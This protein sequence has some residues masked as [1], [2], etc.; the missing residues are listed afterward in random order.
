MYIMINQYFLMMD[1][2]SPSITPYVSAPAAVFFPSSK[3]PLFS[4]TGSS[5]VSSEGVFPNITVSGSWTP[6]NLAAL[7]SVRSAFSVF[8]LTTS[9]GI[10]SDINLM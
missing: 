8:L 3:N 7:L 5:D 2:F 10:D 1:D 6:L 9:H 4:S